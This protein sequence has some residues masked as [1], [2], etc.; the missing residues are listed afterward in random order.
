M[1]TSKI[2]L[3][4]VPDTPVIWC[5][6]VDALGLPE[7]QIHR[8]TMP[9]FLEPAPSG[10]AA[11]KDAYADWFVDEIRKVHAETGPV[12]LI[13]HDWG[14]ILVLRA[15]SLV[16]ELVH[17][18]VVS[19]AVLDPAY[20]GHDMARR[21]ATPV[22]GEL[23]MAF[24]RPKA[25]E[26][27]LVGAGM[28][29]EIAA[30]DVATWTRA[31]SRAVLKLYRSAKAL[32]FSGDWIDRLSDMPKN[33]LVI[34]GE[35]DPYMALHFAESFAERWSVPLY[36]EKGAGHWAVAERPDSIAARLKEFWDQ[37]PT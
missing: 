34:W 2:F 19:D 9:G 30:H 3:H 16:P 11:T 17:S 31:K 4:G 14:A 8:P 1:S 5:P 18:W 35:S 26:A 33:G 37:I 28:P 29:A 24:V 20:R 36:V 22:V 15:A 23:M 10:F 7:S 25:L 32:Q 21:W 6:L 27:G 12:D 13:G